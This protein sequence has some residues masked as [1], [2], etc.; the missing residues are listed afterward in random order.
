MC[1]EWKGITHNHPSFLHTLRPSYEARGTGRE[2]RESENKRADNVSAS[3]SIFPRTNSS[4]FDSVGHILNPDPGNLFFRGLLLIQEDSGAVSKFV[5]FL[6]TSPSLSG[7]GLGVVRKDG[8]LHS[9][10]LTFILQDLMG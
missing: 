7:Y 5:R 3:I 9:P 2:E 1:S 10:L 6:C 4:R 8:K